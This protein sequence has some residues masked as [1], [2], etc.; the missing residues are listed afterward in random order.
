MILTLNILLSIIVVVGIVGLLAY[1]IRPLRRPL[2]LGDLPARAPPPH[3]RGLRR[4]P[5]ARS[6]T[7]RARLR[8]PSQRQARDPLAGPRARLIARPRQRRAGPTGPR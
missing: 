1:N 4:D 2:R 3:G 6:G 7:R 8:G 5:P